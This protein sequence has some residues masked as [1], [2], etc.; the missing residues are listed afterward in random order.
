LE[1]GDSR[2]AQVTAFAQ[3]AQV[4]ARR[5]LRLRRGADRNRANALTSIGL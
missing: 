4:L 5:L 2:I 1:C 3:G